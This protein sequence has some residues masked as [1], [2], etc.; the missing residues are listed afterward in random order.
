MHP[1]L[2]AIDHI[3]IHVRERTAAEA[4]Y[5]RV[6]GLT[7]LPHLAHWAEGGGPLTLG[8]AAGVLHL[9]VF[10][11]AGT[12]PLVSGRGTVALRV[13]AA[14]FAAWRTHLAQALGR[15]L[16]VAD[17]GLTHSI[18]FSDPD[19]NPFEFTTDEVQL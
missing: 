9:A 19:G 6:L 15:E 10:E 4:W 12:A 7:R 11:R 2:A 13:D 8:D 14:A 3:H 16:P 17:H 1:P 18:Y 5:A